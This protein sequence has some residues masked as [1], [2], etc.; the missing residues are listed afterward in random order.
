MQV[1][2]TFS[3]IRY[4]L[5]AVRIQNLLILVVAQFFTAQFL[6]NPNGK[7]V[8][9]ILYPSFW[10]LSISTSFIAA[11]GYIINDYY[12]I[13][14]DLINNPKKV[15]VGTNISRRVAIIL[16]SFFNFWGIIIGTILS[17]QIGF[18]NLISAFLLWWYSNYLKRVPFVGN[19]MIGLLTGISIALIGLLFPENLMPVMAFSFFA[20]AI[21]IIR[22]I[23]KD[24]EDQVGDKKFG[25][26]TL[27][28]VWGIRKTK[29][30][31]YFLIILFLV[32]FFV[33][34]NQEF[35]NNLLFMTTLILPLS[36][37]LII[38]IIKADKKTDFHR[39]SLYCK[40]MMLIGIGSM[41]FL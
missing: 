37:L 34:V 18:I 39:I 19:V 27:P 11:A 20:G 25:C 38:L 17:F 1:N 10:M 13:K 30:F 23:V 2:K 5:K 4:V 24:I 40:L 32:A 22:E 36:L 35:R 3:D 15:V 12:D 8:D 9:L 26:R 33:F 7:L 6:G 14:I 41:G 28:V 31:L 29:L 21:T 16:H